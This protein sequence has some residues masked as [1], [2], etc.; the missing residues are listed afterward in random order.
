MTG[1]AFASYPAH[2]IRQRSTRRDV[3]RRRTNLHDIV[4]AMRPTQLVLGR[5]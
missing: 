4:A 2:P 5:Q 3:E 1:T